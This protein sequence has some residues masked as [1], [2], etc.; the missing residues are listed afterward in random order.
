ML[1]I[2]DRSGSVQHERFDE[3]KEFLV[4]IVEDLEVWNDK[5][6]IA[7]V[8][9]S[10][11]AVL[12]FDLNDYNTKQDIQAAIRN[13][14]YSGGRTNIAGALEIGRE[15]V[16]TVINGDRLNSPVGTPLSQIN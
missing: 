14:Q 9:F 7:A 8:S 13:I 5:I 15:Q 12:E 2:L 16:F 3:V 10:D 4:N 1:F 11:E 6:R